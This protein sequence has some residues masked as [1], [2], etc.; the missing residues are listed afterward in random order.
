MRCL[1]SCGLALVVTALTVI[2]VR[3]VHAQPLDGGPSTA[4][5]ASPSSASSPL[6]A[7]LDA[8][9]AHVRALDPLSRGLI[10]EGV[11]RSITFRTLVEA[12]DASDVIVHLETDFRSVAASSAGTSF[13]AHTGVQRVLRITLRLGSQRTVAVALLGHEL[14]HVVEVA[15]APEVVSLEGFGRLFRAIGLRSMCPGRE[16]ACFE[17]RAAEAAYRHVLL[18]LSRPKP[19]ADTVVALAP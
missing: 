18:D 14:Q 9:W 1:G 3:G 15:R 2:S 12:I 6:P 10:Q 11:H 7:S 8:Q 13:V 5:F 16:I 19:G 17:T 4:T